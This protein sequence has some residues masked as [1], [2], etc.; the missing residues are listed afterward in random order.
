VNELLANHMMSMRTEKTADK[1]CIDNIMKEIA[2]SLSASDASTCLFLDIYLKTA[3][4]YY[5]TV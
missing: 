4:T 3:T 1:L 2:L 5:T